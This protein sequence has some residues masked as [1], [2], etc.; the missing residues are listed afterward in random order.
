MMDRDFSSSSPSR[1][2]KDQYDQQSL[3]DNVS[4]INPFATISSSS[5]SSSSGTMRHRAAHTHASGQGRALKSAV[6]QFD[7]YRHEDDDTN[8]GDSSHDF[9][10]TPTTPAVI[11]DIITSSSSLMTR[12]STMQHHR[13]I[14]DT[15]G[16]LEMEEQP[17]FALSSG[18]PLN[19]ESYDEPIRTTSGLLLTHRHTPMPTNGFSANKRSS[20]D[21]FINVP[22][23]RVFPQGEALEME[24]GAYYFRPSHPSYHTGA[25]ETLGESYGIAKARRFLAYVRLWNAVFCI[26]L[27]IGTGVVVHSM[28][29]EANSGGAVEFE[30]RKAT[31]VQQIT[32]EDSDQA[33]TANPLSSHSESSSDITEQIILIPLP[34]A[35]QKRRRMT[36]AQPEA[37][38]E[39]DSDKR[40]HGTL[41]A[42]RQV[43]EEWVQQHNKIYDSDDDKERRFRIW[44][45]NHH[46]TIQ[47]NERHGPCKLTKQPVFG[48]NH[49]K[50]LTTEEFQ[51]K[52]LTGY[53]GPHTDHLDKL[54]RIQHAKHEKH[55]RVRSSVE[56]QEIEPGIVFGPKERG[57]PRTSVKRHASVQERY[58]QAWKTNTL[59]ATNDNIVNL[60]S[61]QA[62]SSC[63]FYNV[64]CWLRWLM[65]TF[66]YGIG[67]TMEP[68]YDSDSYP[69][70]K[71]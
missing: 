11:N 37:T 53:K 8:V 58:L 30:A 35:S 40:R 16:Y 54:K 29:H 22:A 52:Y 17:V 46:R 5:R 31:T 45:D 21:I 36:V 61:Y 56:P 68:K 38:L 26:F 67:G 48:S 15:E 6:R 2:K 12:E 42:L 24:H 9:T 39:Q 50:D 1:T 19:N 71:L 20:N 28:R 32:S 57:D 62:S 3:S 4:M 63:S 59:G 66:A 14:P 41:H 60:A 51:A 64:S 70:G 10:P 23:A 18:A 7:P 13:L 27:L 25:N 49:F 43:F 55:R 44:H 33:T 34:N 65:Y 69:E 47:K